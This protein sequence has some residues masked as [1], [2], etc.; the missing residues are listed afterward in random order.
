ML[1]SSNF[2]FFFKLVQNFL[3]RRFCFY[4]FILI[5][6]FFKGWGGGGCL[7]SFRLFFQGER[8]CFF[9]EGGG[10]RVGQS[11]YKM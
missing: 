11:L 6:F 8:C 9:L 3:E 7:G 10:D 2:Y 5:N 1:H 4:H